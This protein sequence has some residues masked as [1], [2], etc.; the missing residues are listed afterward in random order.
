M[1]IVSLAE[2][3]PIIADKAAV[4]EA[5]KQGF[6]DHSQGKI[7]M[8]WPLQ[9]N[10]LESDQS[11]RGDCHIKCAYSDAYP[12]FCVKMATGFYKNESKGLPV[13]NGML[14]LVSSDTGE[15]LAIL[16]DG[17]HLTASRTAAAGALS[18]ELIRG[19]SPTRLGIVGAGHQAGLQARW[20]SAHTNV[21]S[22]AVWARNKSSA[23]ELVHQLADLTVR[24]EAVDTPA[25]LC[26]L[27]DVVVTTT[28]ST[29][30]LIHGDM[31]Q[32]GQGIVALGADSKGKIEVDPSVFAKAS[33]I[34]TDDHEQCLSHGDFGYAQRAG[35]TSLDADVSLGKCLSGES[36]ITRLEEDVT[37]V[38]LTGLGAQDLAIATLVWRNLS[39]KEAG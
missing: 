8:P 15:P 12:F 20:I 14:M 38:D 35:H 21:T 25:A 7:S 32:P 13:N 22:I 26:Q 17:G 36:Q 34:V 24:V 19:A 1:R 31:I 23:D 39:A 33:N 9:M 6:I 10:F 3:E 5:V 16:Q 29:N 18:V 11:L 4:I 28:P 2:I 37:I 30:P 27:S